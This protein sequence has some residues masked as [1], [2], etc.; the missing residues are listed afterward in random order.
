MEFLN[1]KLKSGEIKKFPWEE[2][3][4]TFNRDSSI[5]VVKRFKWYIYV[6]CSN[7]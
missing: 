7:K 3:D 5:L 6:L 1:I 2:C 4:W